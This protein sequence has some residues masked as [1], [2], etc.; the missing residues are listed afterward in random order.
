MVPH[1][2]KIK[3]CTFFPLQIH[4]SLAITR[5]AR[6]FWGDCNMY[7]ETGMDKQ[8]L[9]FIQCDNSSQTYAYKIAC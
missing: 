8:T 1:E 2:F 9:T 5:K 3:K 7:N 6:L 4:E